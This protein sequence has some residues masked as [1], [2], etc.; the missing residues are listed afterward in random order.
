MNNDGEN[1]VSQCPVADVME[2]DYDTKRLRIPTVP[3]NAEMMPASRPKVARLTMRRGRECH[4]AP[5]RHG[6]GV[7]SGNSSIG[8]NLLSQHLQSFLVEKI[9]ED[10][11]LLVANKYLSRFTLY[12]MDKPETQST[13][14]LSCIEYLKPYDGSMDCIQ[15]ALTD[16][17]AIV[18]KV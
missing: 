12:I 11:N 3:T 15:L 17:W 14:T 9:M 2:R 5:I 1:R 16:G 10:N 8:V 6:P 13:Q 4:C 18:S 7:G